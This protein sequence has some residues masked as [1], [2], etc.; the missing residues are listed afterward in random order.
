MISLSTARRRIR[1]QSLYSRVARRKPLIGPNNRYAIKYNGTTLLVGMCSLLV[2]T[3]L[4]YRFNSSKAGHNIMFIALTVF[5]IFLLDSVSI[6]LNTDNHP[7]FTVLSV[8][9]T[10]RVN[11]IC[12][13]YIIL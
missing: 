12:N 6:R 8:I 13:N 2:S 11:H 5:I 3:T 4:N 10:D 7:Q 1:R 9:I